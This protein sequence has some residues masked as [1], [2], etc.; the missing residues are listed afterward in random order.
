M[1][2]RITEDTFSKM[3]SDIIR[4]TDSLKDKVLNLKK[5]S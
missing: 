2:H 1:L 5:L 3:E 4:N